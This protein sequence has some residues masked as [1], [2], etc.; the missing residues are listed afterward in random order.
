MSLLLALTSGAS[1]TNYVLSGANGSYSYTG[2]TAT[3]NVNRNLSG[4]TGSYVYTGQTG[5]FTVARKLSGV[6]GS[7]G[8]TGKAGTFT[9]AR[10]LAGDYGSY[11]YIG[12]DASFTVN[13]NLSGNAG[14]YSYTGQG[15]TLTHVAGS[16]KVHGGHLSGGSRGNSTRINRRFDLD[17]EIT[18]IIEDV[19]QKQVET[20]SY[21]N[22][23]QAANELIAA[24][25]DEQIVY[26]KL[27]ADL[28]EN[29]RIELIDAEIIRLMNELNMKRNYQI[30]F[31]LLMD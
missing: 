11:I 24:L 7:Y 18:R 31:L 6:S 17:P 19:A 12:Q 9:V 23:A 13:R 1:P 20:L 14:N 16:D 8:Y 3:F 22:D 10:K 21:E 15:A 28:L 26:E 2:Q 4:A 25:E 30:A 5:T 29:R 27:Y